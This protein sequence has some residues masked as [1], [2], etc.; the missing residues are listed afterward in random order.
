MHYIAGVYNTPVLWFL[1]TLLTKRKP[2]L[3]FIWKIISGQARSKL[4]NDFKR[5]ICERS[6]LRKMFLQIVRSI[7]FIL[8]N[9]YLMKKELIGLKLILFWIT[10]KNFEGHMG[11]L[12]LLDKDITGLLVKSNSKLQIAGGTYF[13]NGGCAEN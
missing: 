8:H 5:F 6:T 7:F 4:C 10:F 11:V 12:T 3:L 2:R 9:I 1:M 13:S